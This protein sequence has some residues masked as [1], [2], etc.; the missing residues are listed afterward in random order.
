MHEITP[1]SVEQLALRPTA[2]VSGTYQRI[3][4]RIAGLASRLDHRIYPIVEATKLGGLSL[5]LLETGHSNECM[6]DH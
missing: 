2:R 6:A 1:R 5:D 4:R 3:R